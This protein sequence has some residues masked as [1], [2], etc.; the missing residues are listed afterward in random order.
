[1]RVANPKGLSAG[2]SEGLRQVA[3]TFFAMLTKRQESQIGS[4]SEVFIGRLSLGAYCIIY[5]DIMN[6]RLDT[7]LLIIYGLTNP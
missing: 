2:R 4:K 1:M 5:T 3:A 6:Y 7:V